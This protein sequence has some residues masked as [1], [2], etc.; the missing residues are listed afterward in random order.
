MKW[1]PYLLAIS[2]FVFVVLLD[3]S[4]FFIATFVGNL[5][6]IHKGCSQVV[7][8]DF[9]FNCFMESTLGHTA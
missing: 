3:S 5:A 1:E 9:L 8:H 2:H 4:L 6:C 7:Y